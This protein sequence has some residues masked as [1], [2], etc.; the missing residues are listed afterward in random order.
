MEADFLPAMIPT[1]H[2]VYGFNLRPY[3]LIHSFF[4]DTLQS[5]YQTG[6]R[7]PTPSDTILA[8]AICSQEWPDL[9][10]L[11]IPKWK[12]W[13]CDPVKEVASMRQYIHAYNS[14]PVPINR[15][16]GFIELGA[17][18]QLRTVIALLSLRVC[19]NWYEAWKFPCV[20]AAWA[21]VAARENN[22]GKPAVEGE[23]A[24]AD[25]EHLAWL[26]S[27]PM[28]DWMKEVQKD[29]KRKAAK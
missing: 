14:Y 29:L 24:R 9:Q 4:L 6:E 8:A 23:Q 13:F 7:L 2:R 22:T 15:G 26:E 10:R 12:Q 18:H 27:Q 5:P 19:A 25:R 11:K 21:T 16:S 1:R 20:T 28:P 17:P 3:S